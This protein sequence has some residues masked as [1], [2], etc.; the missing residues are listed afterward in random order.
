MAAIDQQQQ[1]VLSL[2]GQFFVLISLEAIM[3]I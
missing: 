2:L 1:Q 3:D